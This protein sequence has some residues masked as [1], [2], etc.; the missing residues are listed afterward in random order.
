MTVTDTETVRSNRTVGADA[1]DR[2]ERSLRAVGAAWFVAL[3]LVL[4]ACAALATSAMPATVPFVLALGPAL[5][6]FG[7][8]WREGGGAVRRLAKTA[9]VRP[10]DRRWFLVLLLPVGWALAAVA[11]A[12]ALGQTSA[13]LFD[14]L[15]PT[16]LIVPLV[17]LVP[18]FAEELAWRGYALPRA[19]SVLSPLQASLALGIPWALMHLVLQL[20]GGINA[21]ASWWP[22][23]VSVVAYSIILTWIFIGTGGSV[24]ITALVHTGLNGVVPLM[25]GVNTEAAW[26]IRAV[27]AAVIALTI[28]ALGGL[29]AEEDHRRPG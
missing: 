7:L 5:I 25:W 21:E 13:G 27:L 19:M 23:I 6:A 16:A 18:A 14:K 15:T 17:V 29:R 20:P 1:G 24:L 3:C 28:V 26:E 2:A 11:V 4:A 10:A 8:A 12:V 22:T 9:T